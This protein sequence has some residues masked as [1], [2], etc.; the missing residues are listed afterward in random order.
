MVV[1]AIRNI[2]KHLVSH[3]VQLIIYV[4]DDAITIAVYG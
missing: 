1:V 4:F 3:Q 2:N